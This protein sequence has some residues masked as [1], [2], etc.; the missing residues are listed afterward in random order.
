M[1]KLTAIIAARNAGGNVIFDPCRR[2]V[3]YSSSK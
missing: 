1:E 3:A 2:I